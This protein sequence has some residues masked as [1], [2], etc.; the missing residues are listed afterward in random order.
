MQIKM[1]I[2]FIIIIF[3]L[4]Y[5]Q[6][7]SQVNLISFKNNETL[8]P[9]SIIEI[10]WDGVSATDTVRLE[11]STNGGTNWILITDSV[12]GFRYPWKVPNIPTNQFKARIIA[13]I[14]NSISDTVTIC[15]QL[16]MFK[17]L[18][19]DHYRNGDSILEIQDP[20][21]WAS[22]KTGAWCY[23]NNDSSS[24][25]IYGKLYNWYAVNDK[26]GLTPIGWHIPTDTEW[27]ELENC[28]GGPSIA[29]GKLKAIGT[30]EN[31]DGLW[32]SPNLGASNSSG[33]T[34]IP[35]GYR[36]YNGTF[37]FIGFNAYW[38]SSTEHDSSNAWHRNLYFNGTDINRYYYDKLFGFSVRC[39]KD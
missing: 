7:F 24:R 32:R 17:N 18:D 20:I 13:K 16:W 21:I 22:L 34:A 39:V 23:Y 8:C 14:L 4:S 3:V 30:I 27:T 15:N 10:Q 26:R 6:L 33:F 19:V 38:W 37:D 9:N 2:F 28:L 29:G 5:S 12:S 25:T 31:W 36:Y 35:S 1:N 11:Y